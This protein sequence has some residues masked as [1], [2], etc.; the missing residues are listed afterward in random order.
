MAAT[1]CGIG[2]AI[3]ATWL[4]GAIMDRAKATLIKCLNIKT[5][6]SSAFAKANL[7]RERL[8]CSFLKRF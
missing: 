1:G 2:A 6:F 4:A 7:T 5:S 8:F 3:I